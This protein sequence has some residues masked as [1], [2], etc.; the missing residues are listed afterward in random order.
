MA[1]SVEWIKPY[2]GLI[3]NFSYLS[4]LEVLK[5]VFP[6]LTVPYLF[7]VLG[8]DIYGLVV[9]AQSIIAYLSI[10]ISF[11]LEIKATKDIAVY[12]EDKKKLS[13]IVLTITY[14][15]FLLFLSV[16]LIFVIIVFTSSFFASHKLLYILSLSIVFNDIMLPY[17]YFQ[18]IEQMKYITLIRFTVVSVFTALTF[19]V[20]RS[21]EDYIYVNLLQ[22]VGGVVGGG[23]IYYLIFIKH[24]LSFYIPPLDTAKLYFKE[25]L[26]F[27]S[28]R[29]A[30][31][32]NQTL[33]KVASGFFFRYGAGCRL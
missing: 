7:R 16:A 4:V 30:S 10:L 28:S 12:R 22:G 19:I 8:V 9:F 31:L 26:P 11:G 33:A 32:M 1:K 23:M 18:G 20:I 6:L 5:V 13:E 27:F 25:S 29:L 14:L 24:S 17:W 15:K 3:S 21:P 2:K